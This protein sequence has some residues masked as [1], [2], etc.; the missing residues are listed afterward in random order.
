MKIII[1]TKETIMVVNNETNYS[2]IPDLYGYGS[3]AFLADSIPKD[4]IITG[5]FA[6]G[7]SL[8][9]YRLNCDG[10]SIILPSEEKHEG[11][12]VVAVFTSPNG[13]DLYDL[14]V[15]NLI[16]NFVVEYI[17]PVLLIQ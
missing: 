5:I 17:N 16:T 3:V 14:A 12:N 8:E 15:A 2:V 6:D 10:A 7:R 11:H 9:N 1:D 13:G 4:A